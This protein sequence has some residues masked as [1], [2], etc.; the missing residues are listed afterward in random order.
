MGFGSLLQMKM[1]DK[2]LKIVYYV[3]GHFNFET[4]KVEFENCQ[5]SVDSKSVHEMLGLPSGGS[6]LSNMDYISENNEEI[7]C[8]S[9]RNSMEI[10][11]KL[12]SKQLKNE[13]V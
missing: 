2:P 9:G 4:L 6:L 12:R 3:L 5:L 7:V 1:I 11:D 13:L 8:L 10:F